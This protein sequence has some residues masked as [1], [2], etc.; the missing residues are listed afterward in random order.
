MTKEKKL[1]LPGYRKTEI[2][3]SKCGVKTI[4]ESDFLSDTQ[5]KTLHKCKKGKVENEKRKSGI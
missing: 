4:V 3:C 2:L 5:M 1:K